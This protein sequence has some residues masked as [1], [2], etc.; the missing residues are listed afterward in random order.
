MLPAFWWPER[1]CGAI[2]L[3]FRDVLISAESRTTRSVALHPRA[4]I[5]SGGVQRQLDLLVRRI[6]SS[7]NPPIPS[8][9]NCSIACGS[10]SSNPSWH[11]RRCQ[12]A[13]PAFVRSIGP[14]HIGPTCSI[15]SS[16]S[17]AVVL[18]LGT[19][20]FSVMTIADAGSCSIT[21]EGTDQW[22]LPGQSV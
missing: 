18:L 14:F 8:T 19:K 15:Q 1:A 5:G 16:I 3:F 22:R 13:R 12:E 10:S 21:S 9:M 6:S 7:C 11:I 20:S 2:L 4:T 17:R